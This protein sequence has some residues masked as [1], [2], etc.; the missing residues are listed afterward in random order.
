MLHFNFSGLCYFCIVFLYYLLNVLRQIN[1]SR[2][3]ER[4]DPFFHGHLTIGNKRYQAMCDCRLPT[5]TLSEPLSDAFQSET[6]RKMYAQPRDIIFV[7]QNTHMFAC[8]DD[9]IAEPR[10]MIPGGDLGEFILGLFVYKTLLGTTDSLTR[11]EIKNL[12]LKFVS[13]LPTSRRFYHCND[14]NSVNEIEK[15]FS[16]IGFD[17]RQPQASIKPSL[18]EMIADPRYQGDLHIR[19]LLKFP[20]RYHIS[21]NL[22]L[23]AIQSFY[24]ILWGEPIQAQNRLYVD[25]LTGNH[26]PEAFVEVDEG[27]SCHN[28]QFVPL[29]QPYKN[30]DKLISKIFIVHTTAI[31]HRRREMS[32]FLLN[33]AKKKT[34][35][36]STMTEKVV[37]TR[38]E[39]YGLEW[40][41]ATMGLAC[42]NV[43]FFK[44]TFQ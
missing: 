22:V 19:S 26:A 9:R 11:R 32:L 28:A 30:R 27:M 25:I 14:E 36:S 31:Q 21:K 44:I 4:L 38:L 42:T 39:K 29:L 3:T 16:I 24:E 35:I 15:V 1:A 6:L 5:Q 20:D 13:T 12:L 10:M 2:M 17:M 18:L 33:E 41:E 43:T 34:N 7:K 37:Y 40:L 8:M 23:N